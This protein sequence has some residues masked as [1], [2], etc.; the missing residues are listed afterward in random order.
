M[1]RLLASKWTKAALFLL[2]LL[3]A[4]RLAWG[5]SLV[6][7]GLPAGAMNANPIEFITHATG[8]WTLRLLL[9]TLAVTPL[10]LI[11]NRPQLTRFRRMLGLFAFFYGSLHL[12]T[13][14]WLDKFFAW[15]EMLSDVAMRP[16][17][18]VGMLGFAIMVPLAITSTAGMVRKMGWNRWQKLHRIVYI[19]PAAGVVHY[20][21]LVKSDISEPLTYGVIL[22]LLMAH[23]VYHWTVASHSPARKSGG[24]GKGVE[25]RPTLTKQ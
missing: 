24:L 22:G 5:L 7:R 10:R 25:S 1:S 23:R 20:W 16:Y 21:W 15:G 13:W 11:F 4:V 2:C 12:M 8:D 17:I 19:A 6:L 9:V 18:T 14:M 3:P